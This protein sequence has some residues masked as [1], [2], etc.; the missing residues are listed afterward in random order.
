MK[1]FKTPSKILEEI[2]LMRSAEAYRREDRATVSNFFNGAPPLT[3][4]EAAELGFTVNVNH[5][6]GYRELSDAS[7]QMFGFYTKSRRL[8]EVD[9]DSAEPG[10]RETWRMAAQEE[11]SRVLRKIDSFKSA[12]QGICGDGALHGEAILFH[13][14]RTFPLPQQCALSKILIPDDT[15]ADATALTHFAI[16]AELTLKDLHWYFKRESKGW[17][18]SALSKVLKGIYKDCVPE[19]RELDASNLEEAEYRRQENS[20]TGTRRRPGCDVYYFYQQRA[21]LN[22]CPLDC[23]ILLRTPADEDV[24]K[25]KSGAAVLYEGEGIYQN[26]SECLHPFFMDCIIGGAPKWHR[27]LGLGTLN[28]QINHAVELLVNRAQQATIEGSMNLWQATGAA[29]RDAAQQILLKHNGVIPEGMTLLQNRFAPNFSGIMEMIQFVRQQG[30]KNSRGHNSNA[31]DSNDLLEVQAVAEM[32]QGAT[33]I[34]NRVSNWQDYSDRMWKEAFVRLSNPY[35]EPNEGGYSEAMDFQGAMERRGVPLKYLQRA[36]VQV[37]AVRIVGDGLR[38]KEIAAATFLTQ[39]RAQYAPE[40]QP[41]ITR[42]VTSLV[43]D[44]AKLAEELTPLQEEESSVALDPK[45]ENSIMRDDRQ[46]LKPH[47]A[48]IDEMHVQAHFPALETMIRDA[49][50][51]QKAAFTP[52]QAEAFLAIGGHTVAHIQR[53]EGKAQNN[54]ND[55][56]REKAR[57]FMD[58]VNQYASM[59]EKLRNNMEQ[60]QQGQEQE[61]DPV[62]MQRLQLDMEK[63]ALSREKLAH[64]V[65]KFERTQGTREQALA[66][67]QM[68]KLEKDRREDRRTERDGALR[69]AEVAVK[70]ASAGQRG[71]SQR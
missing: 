65:Q 54:R 13:P 58:Q 60:A 22:G 16:E 43:L 15:P 71:N 8:I 28:Y 38:S 34:N 24:S 44:N 52:P 11:A 14:N 49:V 23:T 42:M 40:V 9:L 50:Q 33:A 46:P 55:P 20:A 45:V 25:E 57:G 19:G 5:L 64:G 68:L 29:T 26:I 53:I 61:V 27:V 2:G 17:R 70:I 1:L 18:K 37:T 35:I 63:I 59:G 30:S 31:G 32:N 48:D 39:N 7:D 10:K 3:D 67:E 51:Y 47:P 4:E 66:F 36:N 69:D 62:E 41:R 56:E 6:F 12:Y 21:D